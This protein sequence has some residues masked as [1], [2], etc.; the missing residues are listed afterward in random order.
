MSL[1]TVNI[2]GIKITSDPEITILKEFRKYL[3]DGAFGKR[4]GMKKI[5]KPLFIATP[6]PEQIVI[7]QTDTHFRNILNG[8]DVALPDGIGIVWANR[9]LHKPITSNV[10]PTTLNTIPG[11]SFMEELT[12]DAAKRGYP[13]A[14][15]G[16]RDGVALKAFECLHRKYPSLRG[17]AVDGPEI[18]KTNHGIC[19]TEDG[20]GISPIIHN[21]KS[22]IHSPNTENAYFQTLITRIFDSHVHF[23]FVGLGAP[24]QEYFIE[25]ITE[26]VL[27]IIG[28]KRGLSSAIIHNSSTLPLVFMSVG[29]SFDEIAGKVPKAPAYI[30][31][32][33]LKWLWRLLHEPWR[34]WRQLRLFKF[35]FLVLKERFAL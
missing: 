26:Y 22:I 6:N 14:L 3:E 34:L 4:Q 28:K 2:L 27:R 1:H 19:I 20:E 10:Q 7:A 25:R 31:V 33:E 13:V 21:T 5:K 32:L 35:V 12:K 9:I 8:A 24:K 30:S 23:V 18:Q 17:W 16:G 15:I 11:V 29:G